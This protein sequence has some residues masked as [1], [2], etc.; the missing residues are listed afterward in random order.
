MKKEWDWTLIWG[1]VIRSTFFLSSR[2]LIK[3]KE[4]IE[5]L[6]SQGCLRCNYNSNKKKTTFYL[7]F[8]IIW[9][10]LF[11]LFFSFPVRKDLFFFFFS[12]NTWSIKNFCV[13]FLNRCGNISAD[14]SRPGCAINCVIH[15]AW[16]LGRRREAVPCEGALWRRAV[17]GEM[18]ETWGLVPS[19]SFFLKAVERCLAFISVC[20]LIYKMAY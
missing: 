7:C 17:L 13:F 9:L 20:F 15:C 6:S 10:V 16:V 4:M 18:S 1:Q 5:T 2:N 14:F 3:E 8:S 12:S 19:P 11:S